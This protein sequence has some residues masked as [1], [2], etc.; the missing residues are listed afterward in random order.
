M[1]FRKCYFWQRAWRFLGNAP[2]KNNSV[3]IA[4]IRTMCNKTNLSL[5]F[6]KKLMNINK[7]VKNPDERLYTVLLFNVYGYEKDIRDIAEIDD[8]IDVLKRHALELLKSQ[9][10]QKHGHWISYGCGF[11]RCSVCEDAKNM[12]FVPNYCSTCGAKMDEEVK[13]E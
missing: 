8:C 13:Q 11:Y 3:F 5:V 12:N 2:S 9:P 6:A 10:E 7:Y 1:L 4:G